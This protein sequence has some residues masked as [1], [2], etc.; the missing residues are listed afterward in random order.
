M[1]KVLR[2]VLAAVTSPE[3]VKLEGA[4]AVMVLT[5]VLLA[6]GATAGL[7]DLINRIAG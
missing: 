6:F 7:V 1:K 3:A 5:R 4:L 2:A